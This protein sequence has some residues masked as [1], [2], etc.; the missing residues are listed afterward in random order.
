MLGKGHAVSGA[1]VWL[2]GCSWSAMA[3]LSHPGLDVLIIG[4]G[5]T[6][7]AALV[8]DF[9]HRDSRLAHSGGLVT[10]GMA[11]G[12]G[13]LGRRIHAA[14]KLDA[15]RPDKDGH[16]TVTHTLVF[17][18]LAGC[19]VAG[20][21]GLA[22]NLGQWI[23][24]KSGIPALVPLGKLLPALIVYVFVRLGF[25]AARA[26]FPGRQN[27]VQLVEKGRRWRKP[28]LI[29]LACATVAF[30]SLPADVWWLGLA[31]TVGC[32]THL[33]GDVI[34]A[35]GCPVLWPL[36]IPSRVLRYNR[37]TRSRE[38]VTRWRTWYLVGIPAW[39][40]FTVGTKTEERVT[41]V[42]IGFGG[43]AL[44]GLVYAIAALP[45]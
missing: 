41:W 24:H 5:I 9:D 10:Y 1:V 39:A 23:G 6:A 40:R 31:V 34:T 20:V 33:A 36:P 16:R 12:F 29:A 15:D 44:A 38:P 14:T 42:I 13:W 26:A 4:S 2:T 18:L 37:K 8:P 30:V 3:G 7:G 45:A 22:D 27:R 21:A 17:A 28:T 32:I 25:A 43:V 11:C 19:L 35:A